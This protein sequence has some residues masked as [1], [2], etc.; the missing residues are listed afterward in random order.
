MRLSSTQRQVLMWLAI[1][2]I[3]RHDYNRDGVLNRLCVM[4]EDGGVQLGRCSYGT[5]QSLVQ[6]GL[7]TW[8]HPNE[9]N[10]RLL[11]TEAGRA[12]LETK[13]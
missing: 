5:W 13:S 9:P 11:I 7:A 2:A 12:A 8:T 1:G 10:F 4:S 3:A 6:R